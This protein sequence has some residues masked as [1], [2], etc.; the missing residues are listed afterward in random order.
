MAGGRWL[1]QDSHRVQIMN[2]TAVHKDAVH[3]EPDTVVPGLAIK[4]I[5][6]G[7]RGGAPR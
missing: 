3:R 7:S 1:R 2:S 4:N 6:A 5:P